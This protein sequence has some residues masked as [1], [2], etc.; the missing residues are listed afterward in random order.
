MP[1]AAAQSAVV[2]AVKQLNAEINALAPTATPHMGEKWSKV[3][4][5]FFSNGSVPLWA[6]YSPGEAAFKAAAG[7]SITEGSFKSAW[8]EYAKTAALTVPVP[9]PPV[10]A[11]T[12]PPAPPDFSIIM[13]LGGQSDD[14]PAANALFTAL[15]TWTKTGLGAIPA[16]PGTTPWV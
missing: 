14:G 4:T 8:G 16:P 12:P 13:D 15:S 6:D 2:A 9:V 7:E 11:Y 1:F 5:A 3:A 10:T